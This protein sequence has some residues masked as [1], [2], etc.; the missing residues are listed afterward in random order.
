[1]RDVHDR[2][3]ARH[4]TGKNVREADPSR[5]RNAGV[6]RARCGESDRVPRAPDDG[7]MQHDRVRKHNREEYRQLRGDDAPQ[8]SLSDAKNGRRE[9][10]IVRRAVRD[11]LGQAS[12]ERQRSERHDERRDVER[13]DQR[14]VQNAAAAAGQQ[15]RGRGHADR[16]APIAIRRAE[17]DRREAHHGSDRQIDPAGDEDRRHRDREQADLDAEAHHLEDIRHRREVRRDGGKHDGFDPERGE[18]DPARHRREQSWKGPRARR[19]R[20]RQPE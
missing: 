14:G 3:Q 15:G 11:A 20:S 7:S 2:R 4:Q 13:R 8:V 1:M 16:Q 9:A 10:G 6:S 5:D 18:E 12:K 19:P 17:D